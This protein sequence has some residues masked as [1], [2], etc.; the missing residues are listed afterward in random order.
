MR[1]RLHLLAASTAAALSAGAAPA[2]AQD[3][4]IGLSGALTGP[5][6]GSYAPAVEGLRLYVEKVNKAGGVGGKRINLILQDDQGQPSRGAAN[7]K[8][9]VTQDNV[10][11]LINS[12]LSATYAPMIQEAQRAGVPLLFAGAVCPKEVYPPAQDLLYCTTAF[13]A[14]YDSRATLDF[15][16]KKAAGPVKLGLAAMAIPVSRGEIDFAEELAKQVGME[17]VDKEVVPPPTADYTPFGTKLQQSGANW[18]YAW[19]PW[20]TEVKTFEAVRKLGWNGD[21]VTWAHP[22]AEGDLARLKDGK[23]YTI[24]ANA[25]FTEKLPVM[26]EIAQAAKDAGSNYPADQMT[27]GWIAGLV[28]EA[29]L[30]GAGSPDKLKDSLNSLK[31]DTKGLRGGP[32]EWTKENHF[33]TKQYYR[34]YRWSPEKNGIEVVQDWVGYDVK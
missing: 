21:Y 14:Q 28:L 9:L 20:V 7:A 23:F 18:I 32:I 25:L 27:E 19:A 33:R 3:I 4:S 2:G 6:A 1:T 8:K 31:V 11:L 13:A 5:S 24:G 30:K 29:A 17:P 10:A 22:E 34:V 15:V 12:S 26:D 16:K